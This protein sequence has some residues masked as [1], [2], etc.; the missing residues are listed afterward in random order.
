MVTGQVEAVKILK[1]EF[2][3][4]KHVEVLFQWLEP[5]ILILQIVSSLFVMMSY[6]FWMG[7][8]LFGGKVIK[9][10]EP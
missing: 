2:N 7:N 3:D 6:H 8:I 4:I 10:N 5:M 9:W 1:A